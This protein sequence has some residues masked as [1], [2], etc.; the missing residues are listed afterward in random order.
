VSDKLTGQSITKVLVYGFYHKNNLGDDL[1]IEAFHHLFPSFDFN[2]VDH[3][4]EENL[5][6]A[7]VVIFGGGSFLLGVPNITPGAALDIASK[8]IYYLGVGVERDIHPIHRTLMKQARLIALRTP[9]QLERVKKI[10]PNAIYVPDL[11]YSLPLSESYIRQDNKI[12]IVPSALVIPTWDDP[13]WMHAAWNYF[14]S[15]FCQFLDY[16]VEEGYQLRMFAMCH[17]ETSSDIRAAYEIINGMKSRHNYLI[18][19]PI[20]DF[21]S[22]AKLFSQ[23]SMVIT[24]RFHGIVLSEITKTPYLSIYHHDKLKNTFADNALSIP[25]Y[26]LRKDALIKDFLQT[27]EMKYSSLLPIETNIFEE[28][29]KSVLSSLSDMA[30]FDGALCRSKE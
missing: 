17:N 19:R 12:L 11:V 2:F 29:R 1:F 15:E 5:A 18:E 14:K 3:I 9:K 13:Q 10:N 24:Q 27:K 28:L 22:V 4:D 23:C 26:G 7:E 16:L 25:Y 6:P 8:K 20:N 21:Q 30:V